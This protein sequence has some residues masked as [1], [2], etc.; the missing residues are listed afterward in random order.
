MPRTWPHGTPVRLRE[1]VIVTAAVTLAACAAPP[2][3]VPPTIANVALMAAADTNPT[4]AGQPAPVV[5][6]VYQLGSTAAFEKA[7]FYQLL[8]NDTASLGTDLVKKDEYLLAP[9]TSKTELLTVPD[10]VRAIGVFAAYREFGRVTWRATVALPPHATT[11]VTVT[12]AKT[13][14]SAAAAP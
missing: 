14:I 3:P 7:E 6:R 4:R 12:A 10:T 13:G 1:A 5:V 2:A 9:G 11:A 8:N